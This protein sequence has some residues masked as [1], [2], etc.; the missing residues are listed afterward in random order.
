MAHSS[1][2]FETTKGGTTMPQVAP[3]TPPDG[4]RAR[5]PRAHWKTKALNFYPPFL[6]AGIRVR[7]GADGRTFDVRMKLSAFNRNFVGTHFGGS[8]YAMC[9]PF[10]MPRWKRRCTFGDGRRGRPAEGEPR[11]KGASDGPVLK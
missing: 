9:D 7:R 4:T 3:S 2:P 5:R 6:G 8:L 1:A 10:F 11:A